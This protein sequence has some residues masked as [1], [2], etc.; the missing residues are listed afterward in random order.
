MSPE[1]ATNANAVQTTKYAP[2]NSTNATGNA[3]AFEAVAAYILMKP[4]DDGNIIAAVITSH[5]TK[6]ITSANQ[7]GRALSYRA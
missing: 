4:S 5:D 7:Y 2:T 3:G 6:T 1:N